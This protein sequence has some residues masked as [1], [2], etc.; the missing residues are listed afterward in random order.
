M[1]RLALV[2]SLLAILALS[3]C[4]KKRHQLNHHA[5]LG[6]AM[7]TP[8]LCRGLSNSANAKCLPRYMRT[9]DE[10]WRNCAGKREQLRCN[11]AF[12]RCGDLDRIRQSGSPLDL[13][14]IP[15]YGQL[16]PNVAFP[17][18]G[19][20]EWERVWCALHLGTKSA[21]LR[22]PAFSQPPDSWKCSGSKYRGKISVWDELSTVYVTAQILG[23]DKLTHI[24]FTTSAMNS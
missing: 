13:S 11:F 3:S 10:P 16:S 21:D 7:P 20:R 23:Y 5:R 22:H 4:S 8:L 2:V 6:E 14:K 9:S 17:D 19:T 24:R 15:T 1:K 12:Q 18:S